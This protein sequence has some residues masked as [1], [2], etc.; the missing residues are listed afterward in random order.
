[1]IQIQPVVF[2]LN[3]GTANQVDIKLITVPNSVGAK[4]VYSL[5]DNTSTPVKR[6]SQGIFD[7]TEEDFTNHGNDKEWITNYVIQQ[8]GISLI[9]E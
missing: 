6:L 3:L 8:L 9:V 7:I 4:I 2:P 1:M 5:F